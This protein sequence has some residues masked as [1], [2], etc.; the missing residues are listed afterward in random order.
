VLQN[1]SLRQQ[2][3]ADPN[4]DVF[5][6]LQA[7]DVFETGSSGLPPL[8]AVSLQTNGNSF[9][10]RNSCPLARFPLGFG[11]Q[12]NFSGVRQLPVPTLVP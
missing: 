6:V 10:S 8:L 11:V 7:N 9:F 3:Q 1:L 12:L 2:L 4:K 5:A